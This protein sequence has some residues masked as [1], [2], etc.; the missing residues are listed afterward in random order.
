MSET[1]YVA[2]EKRKVLKKILTGVCALALAT[3]AAGC[4]QNNETAN[5]NNANTNSVAANTAATVASNNA[6]ATRERR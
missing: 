2:K 3:L 5:A 6:A 1:F 4:S